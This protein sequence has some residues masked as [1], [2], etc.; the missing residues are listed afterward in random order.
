MLLRTACPLD[1]PDTCSLEVEVDREAATGATRL[2]RVDAAPAGDGTNPFTQG[3]IC[4]K[5][6]HHADRVHGPDRVLTPLVRTGPKG[7]GSLRSA[8]W[9][10]A[11]D[12]VAEAALDAARRHGPESIVPYLYNSSTGALARRA[13]TPLL[14][15]KFG[16]SRVALTICAATSDAAI[17]LTLGDDTP[18]ADPHDVVD[19]GLVV[20][21]GANPTVSNTHWP[22]LVAE[23]R[24]RGAAV[25]A[26]DPRRTGAAARAD[27][28]LAVRPGTDVVLALALANRLHEVGGF[29][30]DFVARHVEGL[31]EYL[32]A[33]AAWPVERAAAE[34]G[35]DPAGIEELVRLLA[36][37]RPAYFRLGWG[38]E[39][40][41]NGGSAW[42]AALALPALTGNFGR[43][44][45][46]AYWSTSDAFPWDGSALA[47][48][49]LGDGDVPAPGRLLNQNLLGQ[50]LTDPSLDPPIALLFVQ[51]SN[52]AVMNPDQATM[53]A[54]LAR[55]DLFCVVHDQVLTDTAR[56]ADVVLP[57][58]TH[59]E[60]ADVTSS[61]GSH[62]TER[63]EPVIDRVGESRTNDEVAA[64]LAQRFGYDPV[65]FDPDPG[66]LAALAGHGGA[67]SAGGWS[68]LDPGPQ[69]PERVRLVV[70]VPGVDRVP[71]YRPLDSP[72]PL[73]LLSPANA[74]TINSIFGERADVVPV[75]TMHPDD[76]AA[77][78]IADGDQV[79]V[80]DDRASIDL[81]VR[82]DAATR[83]GVVVLPKG[84]WRR[85]TSSGWTANAFA[86]ATLSDLAGGA[87][88]NDAR[89]EVERA[90]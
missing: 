10:E 35:V 36:E 80:F 51:G 70:E 73:T 15:R 68:P 63:W 47:A 74:Q 28:H 27:L 55:E 84:L 39:R 56:F 18:S 88:F 81:P 3:W 30:V 37:R 40:N 60:A 54:G 41:R 50:D 66:R 16:A 86:P 38:M 5:V 9:D 71:A 82:V 45:A 64:G 76:S 44:G 13:L 14:W 83:P 77:R 19:A 17:T 87:C 26:I 20:I 34:C 24:R 59:F 1:C 62:G 75:L 12:L 2:V 8:S 85:A 52:P 7:S 6:K 33:A 25:V 58:V 67:G 69:R 43:P 65:A 79:R 31:D 61:Y 32:A 49:V 22:P 46:G 57:A 11:L 90:R 72:F 4:K 89:V 78:G 21:W 53:L 23:A 29:D 48:D 42:R